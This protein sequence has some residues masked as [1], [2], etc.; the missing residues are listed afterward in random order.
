[1]VLPVRVLTKLKFNFLSVGFVK[2]IKRGVIE[3][4][5]AP[6][7]AYICT[8]RKESVS[9]YD[10]PEIWGLHGLL[11]AVGNVLQSLLAICSIRTLDGKYLVG[12]IRA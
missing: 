11:V 7:W 9:I 10:F 1:M 12:R 2:A 6:A 3:R 8:R 4:A 5:G